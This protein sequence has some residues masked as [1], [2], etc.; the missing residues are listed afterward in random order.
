MQKK[1]I[2]SWLQYI[3][4]SQ[5]F[6]K[7]LKMVHPGYTPSTVLYISVGRKRVYNPYFRQ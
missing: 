7:R 6:Q 5:M 2:D 3:S 1:T 4:L